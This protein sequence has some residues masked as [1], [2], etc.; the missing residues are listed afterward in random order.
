MAPGTATAMPS[1]WPP[2]LSIWTEGAAPELDAAQWRELLR[3]AR[4]TKL[5]GRL[6]MRIERQGWRASVPEAVRLRLD[7]AAKAVHRKHLD[8]LWEADRLH[9]A[10]HDLP[11]RLVLLKGAAYVLIGLP[12]S[13]G[14]EFS[15]VD[16]LVARDQ[17]DAVELALLAHGWV[18]AKLDP[19]DDRFYRQKSHE[20]P[21]MQHV[22]RLTH[23]DVHHSLV[24]ATSRYAFD[25]RLMLQACRPVPG[26]PGLHVLAPVDMVLHSVV[27][28]M[29][30]GDFAGAPRDLL[31]LTD[32][33]AAFSADPAFWPGL[34]DRA[35][36][37]GLQRPLHDALALAQDLLRAQ[38]PAALLEQ[39]ARHSG[40]AL[41]RQA[42]L[43]TM[44][45]A[46]LATLRPRPQWLDGVSRQLLYVRSHWLRMPWHELLPHLLRK[47]WM[48]TVARIRREP[49]A[50]PG[51]APR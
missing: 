10:L 5:L 31:D 46:V 38:I 34:V 51:A 8:T 16:I 1:P 6:A 18:P 30:E 3:Q 11:T 50:L 36:Q 42:S 33:L 41:V 45:T 13:Q 24:P 37:L 49:P 48:R 28:L 21:P 9:N 44:R 47:S 2:L 12:G 4:L 43:W 32:L 23:L 40:P 19:Y 29:Q 15:D 20:L 25:E 26:Q 35:L 39:L 22:Q 14:R 17:L 7:N 27:H